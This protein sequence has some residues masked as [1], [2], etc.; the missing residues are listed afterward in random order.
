MKLAVEAAVKTT[1]HI[2]DSK[3]PW[4]VLE[5]QRWQPYADQRGSHGPAVS[6]L[7]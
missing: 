2:E 7:H 5:G 3:S 6:T 4:V 1:I